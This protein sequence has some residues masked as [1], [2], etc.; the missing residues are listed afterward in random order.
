LF[1]YIYLLFT[2]SYLRVSDSLEIANQSFPAS[3]PCLPPTIPASVPCLPPT[4][5]LLATRELP[6][7]HYT[8]KIESFSDILAIFPEDKEAKYESDVFES[9]GYK[10]YV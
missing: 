1:S 6:P 5:A 10:W 3:V 2:S 8:F 9:G 7:T 4:R